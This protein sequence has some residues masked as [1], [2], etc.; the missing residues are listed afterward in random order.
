[1]KNKLIV[2]CVLLIFTAIYSSHLIS[3]SDCKKYE[4]T[5]NSLEIL[6]NKFEKFN[7][8]D[9]S[10]FGTLIV[11]IGKTFL[12]TPYKGG[13]LEG[14]PEICRINVEGLDCV[15]FFETSL[16]IARIVYLSEPIVEKLPEYII[17]TRYIDG[18][19]ENYASRLH[20]TSDWIYQNVNN[21][22]IEDITKSIGGEQFKFHL[23]FMSKNPKYYTALQNHPELIDLIKKQE[24]EINKRIYFLLSKEKVKSIEKYLKSGDIIAIVGEKR[25]LDYEHTGLIYVNKEGEVHFM[26]ASSDKKKVIIDTTLSEYLQKIRKFSAISVLRP[27]AP[28]KMKEYE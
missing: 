7:K 8:N 1:M 28:Q 26:H 6:T 19:I 12:G 17:Q 25:D 11:E 3:K 22:I 18:V 16:N 21:K 5:G 13:T 15:T 20:Y 27:L 14:E 9:D 10:E 24:E 2:F 23:N 4:F